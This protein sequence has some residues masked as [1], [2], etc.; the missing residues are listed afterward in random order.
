MATWEKI[1]FFYKTMLNNVDGTLTSNS[2]EDSNNYDVANIKNFLEVN[3]WQAE[4]TGLLDPIYIK[5]DNGVGNTDTSDYLIILGHN[6][7]TA[8][9]TI[10]LQYS[11][12]NFAADINTVVTKV[13]EA[14]TVIFEEFIAPSPVR[15][16]R[17]EISGHDPIVPYMAICVWGQK[18]ILDFATVAYDPY[19][20]DI[21]G[22][23]N[24]S[25]GG[26]VTGIHTKHR[27]RSINITIE[28]AELD[29]Y[30]DIKTWFEGTW[31]PFFI[32]WETANNPDDC[33][34]VWTNPNMNNPFTSNS[35]YRNINLS[36][37]G[38]KE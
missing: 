1:K 17:L 21:K 22:T 31:R 37:K 26:K 15:Y 8:G 34:L 11:T 12:D 29:V 20:Q 23:V 25:Y 10:K 5:F 18:T 19:S 27:D 9:A 32:A 24:R 38:R 16:W 13:V 14:D 4:A 28:D 33:W 35:S 6:L 3:S 7:F 36:L 30:N 2:T